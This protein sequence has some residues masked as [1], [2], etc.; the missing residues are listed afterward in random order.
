MWALSLGQFFGD[1]QGGE[2]QAFVRAVDKER[3]ICKSAGQAW[4]AVWGWTTVRDIVF[5]D[6]IKAMNDNAVTES[7]PRSVEASEIDINWKT[8]AQII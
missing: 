7:L 1:R 6:C 5:T 4:D 8:E 3:A 2:K